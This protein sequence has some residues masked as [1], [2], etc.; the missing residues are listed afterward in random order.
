MHISIEALEKL[1]YLPEDSNI[2]FINN[3]NA[4]DTEV[5]IGV[6]SPEIPRNIE[7]SNLPET[8]LVLER[9]RDGNIT[10]K[11]STSSKNVR[12]AK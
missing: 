5:E 7:C 3:Y 8:T 6:I 10:S 1:L 12:P 11:F 4:W 9:G 2:I